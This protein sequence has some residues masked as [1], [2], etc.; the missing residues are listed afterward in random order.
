MKKYWSPVFLLFVF[1]AV[2]ISCWL[3]TDKIFYLFN[4]SYIGCSVA[5]GVFLF[6]KKYKNARRVT[7]LLVGLYIWALSVM[8]ICR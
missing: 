7:Q 2:A 6:I 8:K 1:E 4:F 3:A 5:L